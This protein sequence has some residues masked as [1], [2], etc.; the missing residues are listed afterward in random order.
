MQRY[1]AYNTNETREL[2]IGYFKTDE[3][4][5]KFYRKHEIEIQRQLVQLNY[6][7]QIELMDCF[8]VELKIA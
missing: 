3:E 1:F 4:F 2:V 7:A 6:A 8:C 5:W